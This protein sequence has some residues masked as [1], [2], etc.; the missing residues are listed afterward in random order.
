MVHWRIGKGPDTWASLHSLMSSVTI[1][2]AAEQ[3]ALVERAAPLKHIKYAE[4]KAAYDFVTVPIETLGQINTERT[5]ILD[6]LS[7][8]LSTAAHDAREATF[9]NQSVRL[10]PMYQRHNLSGLSSR[11]IRATRGRLNELLWGLVS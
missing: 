7:N 2:A 4:I 8:R 10:Y 3:A 11:W 9:L 6:E 1:A 5:A